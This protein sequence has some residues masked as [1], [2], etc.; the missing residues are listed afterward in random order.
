MDLEAA[1][2]PALD[3]LTRKVPRF[4]ITPHLLACHCYMPTEAGGLCRSDALRLDSAMQ[5]TPYASHHA[6]V[7]QPASQVWGCVQQP[8]VAGQ[9]PAWV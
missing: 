3:A 6:V 5:P 7:L 1:A 4:D 8:A 2:H 9:C